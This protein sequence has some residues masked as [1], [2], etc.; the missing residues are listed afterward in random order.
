MSD[1]QSRSWTWDFKNPPAAIWP[2]LADTARF[3]E[4]ARL[5][6]HKITE[7]AGPDGVVAYFGEVKIGPFE[8]KWQERPVNW[9]SEQF[10]EHIRDFSSGPLALLGAHLK[11]EGNPATGGATGTYTLSAAPRNWL[12]KL[13]LAT[14]FFASSGETF[15]RM[16][17]EADRYAAGEAPIVAAD[18]R[19]LTRAL[20]VAGRVDPVFVDDIVAMPQAIAAQA[21]DGD[22]IITMG[23]GSIGATAQ[24]VV[25]LLGA[26]A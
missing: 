3:N 7:I 12:G 8:I 16:V 19:A 17:A 1:L 10:F 2:L 14:K 23:A 15:G 9:V 20:R 11:I 5:P 18:G 4:A 25:E 26:A 22:V 13:L 24:H 6:R 21:K